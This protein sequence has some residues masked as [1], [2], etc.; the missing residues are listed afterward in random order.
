MSFKLMNSCHYTSETAKAFLKEN[1]CEL[2]DLVPLKSMTEDELCEQVKDLDGIISAGEKWTEKVFQAA[3]HIKII[4]RTGAGTDTIDKEAATSHGV[5]VTNT[6]GATSNAVADFA[7][8]LMLATISNLPQR[9]Q[10]LKDGNWK[11]VLGREMGSMTLGIVGLGSIGKMVAKRA[12]GFGTNVIAFDVYQDPAFATEHGVKYVSLDEL[13]SQSDIITIHT[14]LNEKTQGMIGRKELDLMKSGSYVIN[15]S[16]PQVVDKEVLIEKL[17]SKEIAGA[18]IDVHNPAP[19]SPDDPLASLDNVIATPW[20]SYQ[21][22]EGI[23]AMMNMA[24]KEIV[25]VLK[26]E[27]PKYAVNSLPE[28]AAATS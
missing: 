4:A 11:L 18:G 6:P 22:Q 12:K 3:D 16:R 9:I 20:S 17:R 8:T 19:C 28:G 13:M 21:T 27:I 10:D 26:G 23:E 5:W 14:D 24:A 15:T 7:L 25:A 1:D 2:A